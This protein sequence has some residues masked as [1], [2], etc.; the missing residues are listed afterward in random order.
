MPHEAKFIRLK[1][2]NLLGYQF[3]MNNKPLALLWVS[4]INGI[5]FDKKNLTQLILYMD[6]D[7]LPWFFCVE[8]NLLVHVV[9]F[10]KTPT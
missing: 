10:W 7:F 6:I 8:K 2:D 9:T 3:C 1:G 4:L 5:V